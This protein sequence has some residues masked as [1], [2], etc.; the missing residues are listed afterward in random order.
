MNNEILE[1]YP[2]RQFEYE[3]KEGKVTVAY[4][5]FE[6]TI[7]DK[8]IKNKSKRV[9][10]IDLDKIGS[11]VWLQCDGKKSVA[12]I[13]DV[14]KKEFGENE[15]KL[16]ERVKLFLTQLVGKKFIRLYTIK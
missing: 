4:D 16:D 13:I 8:L 7:L 11:F 6:K 2:V 14:T 10:K 1:L 3:I 9:A 12:Q 15:E 5:K